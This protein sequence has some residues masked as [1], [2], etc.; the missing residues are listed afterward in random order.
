MN[1]NTHNTTP[2]PK[3]AEALRTLENTAELIPTLVKGPEQDRT[4]S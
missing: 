4:H 2:F 3:L 1:D